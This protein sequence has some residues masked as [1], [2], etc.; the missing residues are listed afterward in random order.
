MRGM[1]AFAGAAAL[2]LPM[3]LV[4]AVPIPGITPSQVAKRVVRAGDWTLRI[5]T[6]KFSQEIQCRLFDRKHR[7]AYAGQALGFRFARHIVTLGAWVR[8]DAGEPRR[9]QD[10]RPELTRS[11]TPID[12][13]SL[14]NPTDATVW[15][16]ARL[17]MD[18]N[19]ITIQPDA[20]ARPR[21]FHLRGFAGLLDS[22]RARGCTP[23]ARFVLHP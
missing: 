6:G 21:T 7:I 4:A 2:W 5:E 22:A 18:A 10:L 16:P 3:P 19:Q 15:V 20:K 23:E 9:W 11:G 14:D 8:I 13:A 1:M 17:L 12:G